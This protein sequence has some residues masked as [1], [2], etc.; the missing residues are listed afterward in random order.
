MIG[1]EQHPRIK[2]IFLSAITALVVLSVMFYVRIKALADAVDL[3]SHT[4]QIDSAALNKTAFITPSFTIF[5]TI[6][7]I[8]II[9][10]TYFKLIQTL[11]IADS[12]KKDIAQEQALRKQ[13]VETEAFNQ[14]VLESSPDCF[15]IMD[16][17]GRLQFMNANGMCLMEIDDFERYKNKQWSDLWGEENKHFT[18]NAMKIA[19]SGETAQ[20]QAFC[21]T[22]NGTHK[23]WDV[24]ISPVKQTGS[25]K[26]IKLISVS[27][28]ITAQKNVENTLK[29]AENR[30]RLATESSGVGV[31]EWNVINNQ[32]R[33][34]DKMFAIYGLPP[35]SDGLIPYETWANAVL[36]EELARQEEILQETVK[37][38]SSSERT[39][40][41]TTANNGKLRDIE[42]REIVRTNTAGEAEWVVGTNIDVT[43]SK[44]LIAKLDS[45]INQL[46]LYEKIIVNSNDAILITEAEPF[47]LPGPR[48]VYANEAFYKMTGYTEEE[49]IGKTPRILQGPK[50]NRHELDK[51][52]AALKKWESVKVELINYTKDG[53]EFYVEFEIVPVADEKG[54]FTHWVSVQR[55][56]TERKEIEL[57][58]KKISSHLELSTTS[59]VVGTWLLYIGLN[60]L[61]WSNVHKTMWG[62]DAFRT[63]LHYEDWYSII[64][65]EDKEK[66][67]TE[68][69]LSRLEKRKYEVDY[70]ILRAN[71]GETRWIKSVGQY[72]YNDKGEAVTLTGISIDITD[73]KMSEERLR[74]SES[75]FRQ[76]SHLM[77][78]KVSQ[79]DSKGNVV[80]YNQSWLD[81]SG[82]S[83]EQLKDWGWS[84]IMHPD[85]ID[86]LTRRW[87]HS[88]KTGD[89]FEMEFRILH[90]SGQYRWHLS[91][92]SAIK[93]E[94]ENI[95]NWVSITIDI[96]PQKRFA[97][98]LELQV[99]NR[100][101]QLVQLNE[102]LKES[103]EILLQKNSEQ[104]KLNKELESF[105]Y[106]SSHDLQEPLRQI[107]NFSS[108]IS[109]VEQANLSDKGKTYFIKINNAANRMQTLIAD[110]LAYSRAKTGERKFEKT[111]LNEIV[112]EVREEL[113]EIIDEK[114]ATFEVAEMCDALVIPFQF[115]QLMHNIIGN[116]LKFSK[117][118]TPPH[119]IIKNEHINYNHA[120]NINLIPEKEYCHITISD[121]GIGFEPQ[122][123]DR[124]FEVFQRLHNKQEIDGTG[125]GLAIVKKIVE[126]HNGIIT[127]TSEL[128]EGAT[129]DI[130]I[131]ET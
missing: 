103:K 22:T 21:P 114:H 93:D 26:V 109:D 74:A 29:E 52:K 19:L 34:D 110:L 10:A 80:Y 37:N 5:L 27:R 124:I 130:Y 102:N 108:R 121:N 81:Y 51:I 70:R 64:M 55:D 107:Q 92:A 63:D 79:A 61:E 77:P 90:K 117:P 49:I 68:I 54:W 46:K 2:I 75:N 112:E 20:F 35:T 24:K 125:I 38:R 43:E 36:P 104:E 85:E 82:M 65:P 127:A 111:N 99:Q 16:T 25:A 101:A 76:L 41:I 94:A 84:N 48:I 122:F 9:I 56:V 53:K 116:A 7:S 118:N 72:Q 69:E 67:F 98:E 62:Y 59:A 42:A 129:F 50:T 1:I 131:P 30:I 95:K 14:I 106:I 28:D 91:K 8:L 45:T 57:N 13:I 40:R 97:L 115:R 6:C 12:L 126:N 71:D 73:A 23:W 89:D 58:L 15:K 96:E 18:T 33:W 60:K 123:K 105:N 119:I 11:K 86:E 44:E 47:E 39:F 31:W 32:I 83:Y 113:K 128:N 87:T 17:E 3:V 78:E 4:Q 88:V 120:N 66:C 100:T